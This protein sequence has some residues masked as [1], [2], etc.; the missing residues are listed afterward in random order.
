MDAG[1]SR[2]ERNINVVQE[3]VYSSTAEHRTR[4]KP[5][6]DV[7]IETPR[8]TSTTWQPTY[9]NYPVPKGRPP[10]ALRLIFTIYCQLSD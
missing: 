4:A 3:R 1:F 9:E 6:S 7:Y 5:T 2:I 10:F 8:L